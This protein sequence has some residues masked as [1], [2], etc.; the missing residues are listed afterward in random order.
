MCFATLIKEEIK[1]KEIPQ[2]Q[3]GQV[4]GVSQTMVSKYLNKKQ[5]IPEDVATGFIQYLNNPKLLAEFSEEYG[6]TFF[7]VPVLDLVD[8]HPMT[9]ME[10]LIE[11]ASEMIRAVQKMKKLLKN[12][13]V[14]DELKEEEFKELFDLEMQVVDMYPALQHHL[15]S[16]A[17]YGITITDLEQRT[18]KKMIDK[19]YKSGYR[20]SAQV[21]AQR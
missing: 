6:Q 11:E 15:I 12:K 19:G 1:N 20:K 16:M 18:R 14:K 9:I 5:R 7:S 13:K 8:E 21:G 3:L 17:P 10:V 4:V 2:E